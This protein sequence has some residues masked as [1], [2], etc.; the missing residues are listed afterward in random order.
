MKNRNIDFSVKLTKG[1]EIVLSMNL[2]PYIT[3]ICKSLS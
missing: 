1:F 3:I 2:V